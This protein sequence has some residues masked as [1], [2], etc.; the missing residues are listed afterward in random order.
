VQGAEPACKARA[1]ALGGLQKKRHG[2]SPKKRAPPRSAGYRRR[3][4][5]SPKKPQGAARKS[6]R[7]A[8]R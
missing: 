3:H 8:L 6:E 1:V 2:R 4:G 5:R 7:P